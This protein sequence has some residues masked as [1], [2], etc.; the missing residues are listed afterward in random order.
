MKQEMKEIKGKKFFIAWQ[1]RWPT[2]LTHTFSNITWP[3]IL[4]GG[5]ILECLLSKNDVTFF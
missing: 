4:D 2:S 1:L 3:V 5:A